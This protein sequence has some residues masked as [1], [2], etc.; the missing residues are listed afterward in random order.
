[1]WAG[2]SL[3]G[4]VTMA[5]G[6]VAVGGTLVRM[7]VG[8]HGEGWGWGWLEGSGRFLVNKFENIQVVVTW[9]L[10]CGQTDTTENITFP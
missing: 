2:G 5:V 7:W 6:R 9:D 3:Y 1:M 10:S 8:G 4:E